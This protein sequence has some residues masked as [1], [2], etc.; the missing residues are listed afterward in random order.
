MKCVICDICRRPVVDTEESY[1]FKLERKYFSGVFDS[2][3]ICADKTRGKTTID[4][5][6]NCFR[7][8]QEFCNKKD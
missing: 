3:C 5:C 2:G 6:D 4:M 8:F 1:K 7:K